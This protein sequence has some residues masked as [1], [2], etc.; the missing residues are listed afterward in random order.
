VFWTLAVDGLLLFGLSGAGTPTTYGQSLSLVWSDEFNSVTSS[1]VD[2]TKWVFESGNNNGWGNSEKEFYTGRT[3]NA[4][5]AGGLLHIRAQIES[6]NGFNYTSARLKT[7]GLF[8]TTYGRIE[9]RAKLPAG[10]GLWPALWM[11]GTNIDSIG[12]P[13]CGEIDVVEND[14]SDVFFEQGSIHSG[15]DATQIYDFT[16]GDSVTNFHVYDLDWTSNS[17]TWSVNGVAYETQT[18]WGSSTGN[19]YPFPFNQPF[20]LLMNVAVGGSYLGNPSTS[21]I[22]PSLPGEMVIDYIR[23]YDYATVS[24]AVQA[25]PSNG[26]TVSG[27][28]TYYSGTNVTVCA[29]ANAFCYSFV[30][31]TD[32]NSNVVSTSAC[33]SFTATNSETLVANFTSLSYAYSINTSSSPSD[34]GTTSGGGTVNCGS[35][36]TV[37]ASVNAGYAFVNWTE[38]GDVVSLSPCYTFALNGNRMLVANF[39]YAINTSS[40]PS[41]RGSTSGDGVYTNGQV[42]TVC[43]IPNCS[44]FSTFLNWTENG[45]VVSSSACYTF[46]VNGARNLVANFSQPS[47][48]GQN[49]V[50]NP[51]FETGDTSA[52]TFTPA[53]SGSALV[54]D[55]WD[56]Q[57]GSYSVAFGASS[58]QND[59]LSQQLPTVAGVMYD[60]NFWVDNSGAANAAYLTASW[61]GTPVLQIT[62]ASSSFGWSNFD[63][64]VTATGPTTISF[65]GQDAPSWVYL[66]TIRVTLG[67]PP[68]TPRIMSVTPNN[69]CPIGGTAITV[70]GSNF[71]NGATMTIGGASA[72]AVTFVNSN[73]LTAVTP[74][75]TRGAKN[76]IVNFPSLPSATLTNGYTYGAPP[77]FAGVSTVTAGIEGAT[78][79]WGVASGG[80]PPF[81]YEPYV[82]TNS[83]GENDPLLDTNVFSIF[84]PLYP[85]SNSPITYYFEVAAKDACGTYDT[86][87]VELS[88][89]PLLDPNKSQV[90]DGI[91]NGWKQQ[92][93]LNPFD[94][95]VASADP[96]GDGQSNLQEYLAGTDPTNSASSLHIISVLPS[97]IDLLVTWMTGIGRTNALQATAGDASGGYS[98]NSF[99]DIFTVTNTVGTVTNYL[100][101]GAATNA[102]ARYYRVRLV[103]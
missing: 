55:S 82:S 79:T 101:A 19:P 98:A 78:L 94:P 20:F 69:G 73:T 27:G 48:S 99:A 72:F 40:S 24:I 66:D 60:F 14:G 30:N 5:V 8:W 92:Y 80:A 49:L 34:G 7:Q 50:A 67:S 53:G 45:D 64:I 17:I 59:T 37:C 18:S 83:G 91:P 103:P 6:T 1:N 28:G 70:N 81:V 41:D 56:P 29:S 90:G 3:N 96:D 38:N 11:L 77:Q 4:Y 22:N 58:G 100:D 95:T 54:V 46:T 16:G 65:A 39:G 88:V 26:G 71:V 21:S 97:G 52:W 25:N 15:T 51:V 84:V 12:W 32:Q 85:G 68:P 57:C 23:V 35:N 10:V 74:N 33:Y 75:N 43:A 87:S 62:P 76:V 36:V 31:W 44:T 102:P 93:N 89:Q 61:G 47:S 13:G 63:F 42:V 9:W 2:T 86:N